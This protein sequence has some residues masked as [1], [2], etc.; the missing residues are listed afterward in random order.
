M[1]MIPNVLTII[2]GD[3]SEERHQLVQMMG[4]PSGAVLMMNLP[5]LVHNGPPRKD[6]V[7]LDHRAI[8]H[9]ELLQY[10]GQVHPGPEERI[11]LWVEGTDLAQAGCAVAGFPRLVLPRL[12]CCCCLQGS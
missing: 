7:A 5:D 1:V 8:Q 10:H 3:T 11:D 4:H 12:C 9:V 6:A 2:S